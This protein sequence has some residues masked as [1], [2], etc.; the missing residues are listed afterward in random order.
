MGMSITN[1]DFFKRKNINNSKANNVDPSMPISSVD[2]PI[3][4]KY[5]HKI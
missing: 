2:I 5:S 1:F 3:S 4:K